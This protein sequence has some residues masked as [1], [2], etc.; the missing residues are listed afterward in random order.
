MHSDRLIWLL[1]DQLEAPVDHVLLMNL[2]LRVHH[3]SQKADDCTDGPLTFPRQ[4]VPSDSPSVR[5]M[6]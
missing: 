1:T 4:P 5:G 6:T 2:G 3:A